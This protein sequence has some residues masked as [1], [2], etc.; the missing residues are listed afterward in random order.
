MSTQNQ[1]RTVA[2]AV[3]IITAGVLLLINSLKV[4]PYDISLYII[5]WQML[6]I[7][8]GVVSL[9]TSKER[10]TGLIL[11]A[12]G[13]IFLIAKM[14]Y[15]SV[16]VWSILWPTVL[17]IIGASLLFGHNAKRRDEPG[18]PKKGTPVGESDEFIDEV[19]IFGGNQKV[20]TTKNFRGGKITN[21]F[22][23]SELNFSK[24]ELSEDDNFLE[25]LY[26]FGGSTLVVPPDW[27]IR[28]DVVSVFGGFSDKRYKNM[29]ESTGNKKRITIKG[30]VIF[31]GG[32]LK[33][34]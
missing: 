2:V 16:S 33:S 17:I 32:E 4:I 9:L 19:A 11:I 21:I 8:I 31:G 27:E 15:F 5:S 14:N 29:E 13:A 20:I 1:T 12:I 22:G 7:G 28:M 26:I 25:V 24:A 34:Y 6:L 30:L 10:V 3:L 23:G 18:W